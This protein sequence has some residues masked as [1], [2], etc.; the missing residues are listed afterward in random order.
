MELFIPLG[1]ALLL[2]LALKIVLHWA[3]GG[4]MTE[5]DEAKTCDPIRSAQNIH[6]G[7]HIQE[8]EAVTVEGQKQLASAK[9]YELKKTRRQEEVF[10]TGLGQHPQEV[11]I[12]TTVTHVTVNA[13]APTETFSDQLNRQHWENVQA[14]RKQEREQERDPFADEALRHSWQQPIWPSVP[15]E[16]AEPIRI[17]KEEPKALPGSNPPLLGDGHQ[18]AITSHFV[19][20]K[21]RKIEVDENGKE[22][23]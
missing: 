8:Q 9:A 3:N 20:R 2:F 7:Q 14:A 4:P 13:D 12:H 17:Y 15:A 10:E 19:V 22:I 5:E 18:N 1:G 6:K 23:R 11:T 16:P 21:G